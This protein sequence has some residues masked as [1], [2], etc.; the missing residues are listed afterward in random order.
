MTESRR[1]RRKIDKIKHQ[2]KSNIKNKDKIIA[3]VV[4]ALLFLTA[5]ITAIYFSLY[6]AGFKLF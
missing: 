4:L 3:L 2:H 5:A 6:R 1:N